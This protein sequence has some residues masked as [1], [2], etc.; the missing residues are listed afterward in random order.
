MWTKAYVLAVSVMLIVSTADRSFAQTVNV[1]LTTDNQK[2]KLK[3]QSSLSSTGF[4]FGSS[5][6]CAF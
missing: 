1:W 5:R 6:C 3:Q 2:T 4:S